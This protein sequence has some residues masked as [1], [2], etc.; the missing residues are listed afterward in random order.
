MNQCKILAKIPSH[1]PFNPTYMHTFAV[2]DNYIILIEQSLCISVAQIIQLTVT[3]GPMIDAL[4]WHDNEPVCSSN[5]F[6]L[7][8][9]NIVSV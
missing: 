3:H 7:K 6:I 9:S 2:T 4:I 8:I 1:W 5:H